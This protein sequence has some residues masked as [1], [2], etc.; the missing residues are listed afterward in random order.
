MESSAGTPKVII[1]DTGD[2]Q[3]ALRPPA[4][5]HQPCEGRH[6]CR[7]KDKTILKLREE[8]HRWAWPTPTHKSTFT[9]CLLLKAGKASLRRNT[10]TS[11]R[12]TSPA[13]FLRK[14]T[15]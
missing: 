10:T 8:R 13:S 3:S 7:T 9:S 1:R 5:K 4:H 11:C 14:G 2:R 15:N 6:L 12:N